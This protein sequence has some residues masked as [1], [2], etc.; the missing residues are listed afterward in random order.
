MAPTLSEKTRAFIEAPRFGVLGTSQA[1]GTPQL[2]VMWYELQGDEI[3]MNTTVQRAK[4]ANLRRDPR[5]ALCIEDGYDYVTV[6][7]TARLIDDPETA[8]ADIH[9]LATR[10]HNREKADQMTRDQFGKQQRL[11]IR[12]SI[13]RVVEHW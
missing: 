4:A 13:E 3:M 5:I 10:Y 7:G 1:D 2:T 6:Y 9:R 12:M 8:Q 11:T